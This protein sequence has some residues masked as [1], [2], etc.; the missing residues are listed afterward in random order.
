MFS[1]NRATVFDAPSVTAGLVVNVLSLP[2]MLPAGFV[3]TTR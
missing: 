1:L 2:G 3:A